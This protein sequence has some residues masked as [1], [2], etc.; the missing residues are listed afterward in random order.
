MIVEKAAQALIVRLI[1]YT[2]GS[3]T[4]HR[5]R[6]VSSLR[7]LLPRDRLFLLLITDFLTGLVSLIIDRRWSSPLHVA[8]LSVHP[9]VHQSFLPS[10]PIIP[11]TPPP[12]PP[13]SLPP[14]SSTPLQQPTPPS[15]LPP[16]PLPFHP[17]P[18]PTPS[19]PRADISLPRTSPP[20]TLSPST[21]LSSPS[22]SSSPHPL[23]PH[24]RLLASSSPP[25]HRRSHLQ[26][27][28]ISFSRHLAVEEGGAFLYARVG[29]LRWR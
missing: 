27:R 16:A 13:Q 3:R 15:L 9:S 12:P 19:P 22:S 7:P 28:R 5:N 18:P 24:H 8:L 14:S 29:R 20:S 26:R 21:S 4:R 1:V 10:S 6:N 17:T 2:L 23:H 11:G 25:F